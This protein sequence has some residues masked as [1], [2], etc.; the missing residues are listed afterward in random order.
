M[1][2]GQ[3]DGD[4]SR[5]NKDRTELGKPTGLPG[6]EG[7]LRSSGE[8]GRLGAGMRQPGGWGPR[9][10][11][12]ATSCCSAAG[13]GVSFLIEAA[14]LSPPPPPLLQDGGVSWLLPGQLLEEQRVAWAVSRG[15]KEG[16]EERGSMRV[17][18]EG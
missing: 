9:A 6:S 2:R 17:A 1:G 18:V 15:G 10:G 12:K 14:A 7:S 8:K 3:I 13:L 4:R 5:G 11:C 16:R